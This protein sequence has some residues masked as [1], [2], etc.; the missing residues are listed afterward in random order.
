MRSFQAD[1]DAY[2]SDPPTGADEFYFKGDTDFAGLNDT[3]VRQ[4]AIR[5]AMYKTG[6][7]PDH[8]RDV[9]DSIYTYTARLLEPDSWSEEEIYTSEEIAGWWSQ[10][11]I[12]PEKQYPGPH[13]KT[14]GPHTRPPGYICVEHAYLFT[15][16]VRALGIPAREINLGFATHIR[17]TDGTYSLGHFCQEAAA[18]AYYD[19]SWHLY[20]PFLEMTDWKEYLDNYWSYVAWHAYDPK[21]RDSGGVR[22]G[23]SDNYGHN[24]WL[25]DDGT[26]VPSNKSQWRFLCRATKPG[27]V[28]SMAPGQTGIRMIVTGKDGYK[29]GYSTDG[30]T[31]REIEGSLFYK[32]RKIPQTN[33]DS[34]VYPDIAFLPIDEDSKVFYEVKLYIGETSGLLV[35]D[36]PDTERRKFKLIVLRTRKG[37]KPDVCVRK[38][39]LDDEKVFKVTAEPD[40]SVEVDEIQD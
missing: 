38:D 5:A 29:T 2:L 22:V 8:P 7:F 9:V 11:K 17:R 23:G 3:T 24:F 4:M 35:N 31:H 12:S 14:V 30:K 1:S 25:S 28:V 32:Q 19:N 13:K 27:L 40:S 18:Q 34:T 16:L 21:N 6:S 26:G 20:D 15:S 36:R 33:P 37:K 10:G 39:R